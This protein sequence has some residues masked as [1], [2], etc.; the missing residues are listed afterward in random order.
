MGNYQQSQA[1]EPIS[2]SDPSIRVGTGRGQVIDT[3]PQK[4]PGVDLKALC[5][6]VLPLSTQPKKQEATPESYGIRA[7]LVPA[8]KC[9]ET[10]QALIRRSANLSDEASYE[11]EKEVGRAYAKQVEQLLRD[12]QKEKTRISHAIMGDCFLRGKEFSDGSFWYTP[13]SSCGVIGGKKWIFEDNTWFSLRL[14]QADRG[15]EVVTPIENVQSLEDD[16]WL[17][18][19]LSKHFHVTNTKAY[20]KAAIKDFR[21]R[22][23][24]IIADL[25]EEKAYE[26]L[27]WQNDKAPVFADG[28]CYLLK[29]T[30]AVM[31]IAPLRKDNINVNNVL[32][33]ICQG[34]KSSDFEGRLT[35]LL[36]FGL[37]SWFGSLFGAKNENLPRVLLTGDEDTCKIAADAFLKVFRRLGRCDILELR[38]LKEVSADYVAAICDDTLV[39]N[40]FDSTKNQE[41]LKS[42]VLSRVLGIEALKTPLVVLQSFPQK[43]FDRVDFY[44][45]DLKEVT[46]DQQL[47]RA[48]HELKSIL[49]G[50]IES[51]KILP[52]MTVDSFEEV[53]RQLPEYVGNVLEKA[54]GRKDLV[55][56]FRGIMNQGGQVLFQQLEQR[57][58]A[59]AEIFCQRF[60]RLSAVGT[61]RKAQFLSEGV[62]SE[63][64][65]LVWVRGNTL[66]IPANYLHKVLLPELGLSEADFK[67][68]RDWLLVNRYLNANLESDEYTKKISLADG[69]RIR[70]YVVDGSL[71][72]SEGGASLCY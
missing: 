63:N 62:D 6:S 53:V 22:L 57:R 9:N 39:V 70:V 55:E 10:P 18:V 49:L 61:I 15:T 50:T 8:S 42:V 54:G 71:F 64:C 65:D 48:I 72:E 46:L 5:E 25:E 40:G 51:K 3:R 41:V 20:D 7:R 31:L 21:S 23:F 32:H 11:F 36:S 66:L 30:E 59:T 33:S 69:K 26:T 2:F 28:K 37:A 16:R 34:L 13:L 24:E 52:H 67:R 68:V 17:E 38:C 43:D 19:F 27:G 56:T 1:T 58:S 29:D 35:F 60:R 44:A 12:K 47:L 45:V 4:E 14:W